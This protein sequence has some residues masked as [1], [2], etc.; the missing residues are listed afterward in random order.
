M[1]DEA[2]QETEHGECDCVPNLGPSHCHLCTEAVPGGP[3]VEWSS[4]PCRDNTKS[5]D[6]L[7][8]VIG[9]PPLT[10]GG[11]RVGPLTDAEVAK[12]RAKGKEV[13]YAPRPEFGFTEGNDK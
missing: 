1:S 2:W 4:A 6:P 9:D 10:W 12:W 3:I 5:A 8:L 11:D 13:L 7:P